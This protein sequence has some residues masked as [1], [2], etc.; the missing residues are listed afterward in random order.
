MIGAFLICTVMAW[1]DGDSGRCDGRRFRLH[2]VDAA[3]AA[4]F[5]RC[6]SQ[7]SI[8]A[9]LPENRRHAQ[10]AEDRARALTPRGARCEVMDVDRYDRLVLRCSVNGRDLGGRLVAEG[11]VI[12]DP[13]YGR[14]YRDEEAAARR[15]GR[16][17]WR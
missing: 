12:A 16:G 6:R 4:P 1:S 14:E 9:C 11:L 5:T 3:E 7:P 15:D 17:I 8:W 2:G 13:T 10:P